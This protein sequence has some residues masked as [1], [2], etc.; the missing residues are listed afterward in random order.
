M[1]TIFFDI[2]DQICIIRCLTYNITNN[3]YRIDTEKAKKW[4]IANFSCPPESKNF[5]FIESLS[6]NLPPAKTVSMYQ[7]FLKFD[8]LIWMNSMELTQNQPGDNKTYLRAEIRCKWT[9]LSLQREHF[10]TTI[11]W[12]PDG[13]SLQVRLRVFEDLP[14]IILIPITVWTEELANP[15]GTLKLSRILNKRDNQIWTVYWIIWTRTL[16]D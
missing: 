2:N 4:E 1:T 15:F 8:T 9:P 14:A 7:T 5:A 12:L 10:I 6:E 3:N 13:S 16:G 11:F